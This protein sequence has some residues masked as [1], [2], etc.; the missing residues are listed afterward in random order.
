METKNEEGPK[1]IGGQ[2]TMTKMFKST[3]AAASTAASSDL[4]KKRS[5]MD[6][7]MFKMAAKK[8]NAGEKKPV[9]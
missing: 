6:M 7:P 8:G 9:E 4:N 5:I 3:T 1:I 2:M